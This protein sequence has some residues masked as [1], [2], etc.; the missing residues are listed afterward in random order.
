MPTTISAADIITDYGNYYNP[1]GANAQ[2]LYRNVIDPVQFEEGF[3]P[4]MIDGNI[5]RMASYTED[6]IIQAF[7]KAYTPNGTNAFTPRQ[8]ALF[9]LK[10]DKEILPDEIKETW[11]GFL[12]SLS[13]QDRLQWPFPRWYLEVHLVAAAQEQYNVEIAYKAVRVAPT[14]GTPGNPED[15]MNGLGKVVADLITAGDIA[16]ITMGAVPTDPVLFVEYVEDF[17]NNVPE[18]IRMRC[19]IIRMNQTL[20]TRYAQGFRE[21]YKTGV[22]VPGPNMNLRTPVADTNSVVVGYSAMAAKNRIFTS[23]ASNLLRFTTSMGSPVPQMSKSGS[24][25]RAIHI[26]WDWYKL[27]DIKNPA[28][29]YC[30]EQV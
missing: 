9:N 21:K 6:D 20:S 1:E 4:M 22:V 7:Q 19:E 10:V 26:Y 29:F 2:R 18:K 24:N 27:L 12:A 30:S 23:A 14:P 16:P 25:P 15:S 28:E 17:L 5:H 13:I 3:T 11:L 8:F